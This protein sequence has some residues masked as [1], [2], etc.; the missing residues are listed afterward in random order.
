MEEISSGIYY[1]NTFSG[2]TLGAI[3]LPQGTILLD[4]PLRAEEGR[5][6]RSTLN[7]LGASP[8]R[9]LVNLDAHPDRTLGARG[10]DCTIIAHQKT[11]QV[12]RSRPSVFKGQNSESGSEWE[13][14][15]EAVGT[16]WAVPDLTFTEH[17]IIHW[18]P[19][20]VI[21]EQ[22]PG[23]MPGAIWVIMPEEKVI[24]VGDAVVANQPPFLAHADINEWI[25][26]LEFMQKAYKN[27]TIISG[28]GGAVPYQAIRDQLRLLKRIQRG[29]NRI[30]N[31]ARLS[32]ATEKF[33]PSVLKELEYPEY[34]EEQFIHRLRHGLAQ[35]YLHHYGSGDLFNPES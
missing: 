19:Y 17:L 23:P 16:R 10:M 21:F 6:W 27:Y 31:Q 32:E 29:I 9:V 33:I 25:L 14:Y 2:V 5:S 7:S 22:H 26:S 11:A 34:M 18:G 12:F 4:A 24:F 15:D 8:N 30:S 3:L 13:A 28:R 1:E 35:Y 20:P